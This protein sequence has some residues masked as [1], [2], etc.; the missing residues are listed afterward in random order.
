VAEVLLAMV[1]KTLDQHIL[2]NLK[3]IVIISINFD[4]W[5]FCGSVDTFVLVIIFLNEVWALMHVV[6]GL[7][8][9]HGTSK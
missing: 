3:T 1:K 9:V 2:L 8:E 6:V 5:M 4:L 7:L